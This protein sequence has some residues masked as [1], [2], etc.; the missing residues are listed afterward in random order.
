[1]AQHDKS[2]SEHQCCGVFQEAADKSMKKREER[3]SKPQ[4]WAARKATILF[5]LGIIGYAFY[6]YIGRFCVPMLRDNAGVLGG[7][8]IASE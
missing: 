8:N 7:K 5:L 4:S 3:R 1:M 6:V 2:S